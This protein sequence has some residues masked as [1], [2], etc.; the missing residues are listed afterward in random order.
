MTLPT[1]WFRWREVPPVNPRY[2]T[3]CLAVA[4]HDTERIEGVHPS[5][6]YA[7]QTTSTSSKA[8]RRV[9]CFESVKLAPELDGL[10]S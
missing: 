4:K 8:R 2:V 7:R 5:S 10:I 9:K 3:C 6:S 1:S